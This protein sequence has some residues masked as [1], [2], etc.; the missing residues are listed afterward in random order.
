MS[1]VFGK[2][3]HMLKPCST[4]IDNSIFRLHYK[5]TMFVLVACSL[6]LT[7]KQYFSDPIDCYHDG[8]K[9]DSGILDAYCWINDAYTVPSL[10]DK[11]VGKEIAHTGIGASDPDDRKYHSYYQWVTLFVYFQA[12]LFYIPRYLWKI[13]EGGKIKML[14]A[15]LNSPI[16]DE[17]VK[18]SRLEVMVSYFNLN[19]HHNNNLAFLYIACEVLNFVNV[20][21]Q[22]YFTDRF[23][24]FEF[25]TYGTDVIKFTNQDI[26]TRHD[27]MDR[28][29][30]KVMSCSFHHTGIGGADDVKIPALC[31][32]PL[33]IL[34][35]KIFI[36]LW[37]WYI[38]VAV[39]TGIG[40]LYRIVTFH[41]TVRRFM[42]RT[43]AR[44]TPAIAV[45]QVANKCY[46][47][48][49]F[50]LT[51]LAKNMDPLIFKDFM[52]KLG[53]KFKGVDD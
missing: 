19:L 31:V 37:F 10:L 30:P 15:E 47:G 6:L 21:G 46:Y 18:K 39:L 40:L 20:I 22:I 51:S 48:D 32:M 26:G 28:V 1:D 14:A 36:F 2:I 7:Q 49:W 50:F 13:L 33:N 44:L 35:E 9:I 5:A 3:Q 8:K 52:L 42:L 4:S 24:G 17:E 29:F 16:V 23:I 11:E 34:N 45:D 27:P 25:L 12:L 38:I 43:R 53:H 41:P